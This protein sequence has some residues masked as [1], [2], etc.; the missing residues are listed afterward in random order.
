MPHPG[1]VTGVGGQQGPGFLGPDAL[2][3]LQRAHRRDGAEV[4]VE[5][6]RAHP[7]EPGEVGDPHR[8]GVVVADP[9]DRRADMGQG[10][11][12]QADLPITSV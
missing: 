2:L 1:D 11:V 7:G 10:A 6:G 5:R 4:P 8:C 9:P 3:E 12:G